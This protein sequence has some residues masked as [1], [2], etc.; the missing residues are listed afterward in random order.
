[1]ALPRGPCHMPAMT[2]PA[3]RSTRRRSRGMAGGFFLAFS[4]IAGVVIGTLYGQ[5][6]IGFLAGLGAGL[7]LVLLVFLVDRRA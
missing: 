4:L 7:L 1:M 3:D 6:S 2:D 5:P